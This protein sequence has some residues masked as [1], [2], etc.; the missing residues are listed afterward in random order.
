M[1][2][3]YFYRYVVVSIC[4]H[5]SSGKLSYELHGI[6]V[7]LKDIIVKKRFKKNGELLWWLNCKNFG[8]KGAYFGAIL[9]RVTSIN[10]F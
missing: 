9:C 8:V 10:F 7:D 2:Y 1:P 3:F 5:N 4:I 6:D